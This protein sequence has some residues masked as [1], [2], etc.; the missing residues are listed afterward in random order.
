M[1]ALMDTTEALI[2]V[3]DPDGTIVRFNTAC[4]E[5]TGCT[6]E[7]AEGTDLRDLLVDP[8]DRSAVGACL[9]SLA[10]GERDRADLEMRWIV[11]GNHSLIR[12]AAAAL[13]RRDGSLRYAV[14]IGT[15]VTE[16]RR[17]ERELVEISDRE[18]Q[19]IG[20]ELH[21]VVSAGLT[22]AVLRTEYLLYRM[23]EENEAPTPED[24]RTIMT[25]IGESAAQ[26]RAL[27]HSL[28]PKALQ[29]GT[30]AD[31]L[32]VLAGEEEDFSGVPCAFVGD[33]GETHPEDDDVAVNLYRIA[34]EA[35]VN[36]RE[37][38][39]PSQIELELEREEDALVLAV[40]DDGRGW[41]GEAPDEEGLGLYL[42]RRRAGLVGAALH[43]N[44]RAGQTVVECRLPLS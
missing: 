1:A 12:G 19:R 4:E 44:R 22:N 14:I 37:H 32:D 9:E 41:D 39:D 31:A 15:D 36:A 5:L 6:Q 27:S 40:R 26:I 30:L 13:R 11:D 2:V 29:E 8:D 18:S 42:M 10:A 28:V 35:V 7:E 24:L 43:L 25:R 33:L 23:E 17:L 21:D 34:R 38:A 16:Q 3:L 20:E